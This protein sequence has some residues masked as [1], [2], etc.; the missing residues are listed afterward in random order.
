MSYTET[1]TNYSWTQVTTTIDPTV[2]SATDL[3]GGGQADYFLSF[4]V[5]SNDLVTQ[6]GLK[7][8]SGFNQ[9][10]SLSYVIATSTQGNSLN[11]DLS[12]VPKTYDNNS[13]WASLGA[14][15]VPYTAAGSVVPEPGSLP[16]I[17]LGVGVLTV[18][19]SLRR[20]QS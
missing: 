10:S 2:G 14:V 12:G 16:L 1:G 4:S 13:S 7:N 19:A 20:F 9:N 6:L 15:S 18:G 5:P 3:D 11:Q 17:A 8:L